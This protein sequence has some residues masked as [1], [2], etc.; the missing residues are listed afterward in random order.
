MAD[1]SE[2]TP[3]FAPFQYQDGD[4][5]ALSSSLDGRRGFPPGTRFRNIS[6]IGEG[7]MGRV[8]RAEDPALG[9]TVAL[10]LTHDDSDLAL[11][12]FTGEAQAQA[13]IDHPHVVKVFEVGEVQG[14]PFIV[15]QLVPGGDLASVQKH[16]GLLQLAR[17]MQQVAEGVEA[18]HRL[19]LLHRDLKPQNILVEESEGAEPHPFVTDFGLVRDT[20]QQ[21]LT[22]TGVALGTPRYMSPEQAQGQYDKVDARSDVYSL[23]A[24]M[25]EVF[26]GGPVYGDISDLPLFRKI[27]EENPVPLRRLAPKV[28]EDLALIVHTCLA[29]DPDRRYPSAQALAEDLGRFL[30]GQPIWAR[31]PSSGYRLRRALAQ[32]R[33]LVVVGA[34]GL[35]A[36]LLLGGWSVRSLAR[37]RRQAALAGAFG[38]RAQKMETYLRLAFMAPEHPVRPQIEAVSQEIG[39]LRED[40]RNGGDSAVGP[41]NWALGEG[42]LALGSVDEALECLDEAWAKGF[43]TPEAAFSR[44]RALVKKFLAGRNTLPGIED[45]SA[46]TSALANLETHYKAQALDMLQQA[47]R[48]PGAGPMLAAQI[49]LLEGRQEDALHQSGAALAVEPWRYEACLLQFQVW[50]ERWEQLRS[51]GDLAAAARAHE[52]LESAFRQ[53]LTIAPSSPEVWTLYGTQC[54]DRAGGP[55]TIVGGKSTDQLMAQARSSFD[56]ALTLDPKWVAAL[57]NR[58]ELAWRYGLIRHMGGQDPRSWLDKA[59]GD[60][61]ASL[62]VQAEQPRA[63]LALARALL[64]KANILVDQ[65]L[66]AGPELDR[67][68]DSIRKAREGGQK[69]GAFLGWDAFY[70]VEA[71]FSALQG[72][73]AQNQGRDGRPRFREA[74]HSAKRMLEADPGSMASAG[75]AGSIAL[76]LADAEDRL[77]SDPMPTLEE[78]QQAFAG[79]LKKVPD[80]PQLLRDAAEVHR[81]R[82]SQLVRRGQDPGKE[83]ADTRRLL[84]LG[85]AVAPKFHELHQVRGRAALVEA[86]WDRHLGGNG[87]AFLRTA[88]ADLRKARNFN[89]RIA[90]LDSDLH[91]ILA[92]KA[93]RQP[94]IAGL[95]NPGVAPK[96]TLR[97][98]NNR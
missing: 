65:H 40:I 57:N 31:R 14:T 80:H 32:H 97:S 68:A 21:G 84:H 5:L 52:Q 56:Q 86:R 10:K 81:I 85:L 69:T 70:S 67:G 27:L 1:H 58:S 96:S 87:T 43:R 29:K 22:A 18:A 25:Y 64:L 12:R 6:L 54:L 15:M 35:A 4:S 23:G 37:S 39:R 94:S 47:G 33:A 8:Y 28:P 42:Y 79:L 16:L 90:D 62:T 48:L 44:G 92:F 38:Q 36:S 41:G 59:I 50:K 53:A 71:Q 60:A 95:G 91:E 93:E 78:A 72:A 51:S 24:T 98:N 73:N 45:E 61:E 19:G 46:K 55:V 7:G 88:E 17:I 26:G 34:C 9:R 83:L 82:A 89:P 3:G 63:H 30:H 11:M 77:G 75:M 20:D 76:L 13:R 66:D 74:I 49:A 2:K